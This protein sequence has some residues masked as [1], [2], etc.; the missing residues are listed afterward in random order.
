MTAA[1]GLFSQTG[2]YVL[3]KQGGWFAAALDEAGRHPL[4]VDV[5]RAAG[6]C[7]SRRTEIYAGRFC[8]RQALAAL[9]GPGDA[10]L[11]GGSSGEPV[12]P[13]GFSGSV[14]HSRSAAA[15]VVLAGEGRSA[16]VDLEL[17]GRWI[18]DGAFRHITATADEAAAAES[19]E[20]AGIPGRLLLF[21]AKES[22]F[23]LLFPRTRVRFYFDAARLE[24]HAGGAFEA[25]LLQGLDAVHPAGSRYSGRWF[26]EDGHIVTVMM[27]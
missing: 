21:S 23:K 8:A 19:L 22:F 27:I 6:A 7:D 16:G 5:E 17:E 11:P 12:W 14:S 9:G 26:R 13:Q 3:G 20:Q 2:Q 10:P 4:P 1:S 25:V 24:L 15:A 18:S